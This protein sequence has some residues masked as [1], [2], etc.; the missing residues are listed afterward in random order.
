[1]A[2]QFWPK[3]DPLGERITIDK[4]AGPPYTEQPRQIIGVVADVR[5]DE[6]N[7]A[8]LPIIYIPISQVSDGLTALNNRGPPNDVGV[9]R[10]EV[11]PDSLGAGIQREL[12]AASGGRSRQGTPVR[13]T[14]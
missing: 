2:A 1:M 6:P 5:D 14:R 7:R 4:G 3:A 12:R 10:T 13:W 8:L 11:A 9:I